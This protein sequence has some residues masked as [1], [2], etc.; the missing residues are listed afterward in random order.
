MFGIE[1]KER[2]KFMEIFVIALK[3]L[4]VENSLILKMINEFSQDD[5]IELFGGNVLTIQYK[6]NLNFGKSMSILQ[7]KNILN[8]SIEKAKEIIKLNKKNKIKTILIS[9]KNYPQNLKNIPNPPAL[10]YFKGRGFYKKHTKSIA[11]VGTRNI[12]EFGYNWVNELVPKLVNE[13]FTIISGLAEGIDSESHKSCISNNGTTIAV[14]AHGLDMIY[15]SQNKDLADSILKNNGLIISEYPI[16]TEP[17]KQYFVKRNRIIS[18][19][20]QGVIVFET[21]EKSGTMHTV[22]YATD[23][24]KLIFTPLPK[25]L[26]ETT[27]A[28][29]KLCEDKISN[30]IVSPENYDKILHMLGYKI[31]NDKIKIKENRLNNTIGILTNMDLNKSILNDNLDFNDKKTMSVTVN[32]ELYEQYKKFLDINNVKNKDI[33][34]ALLLSFLKYYSKK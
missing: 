29:Y 15:P 27:T 11:C 9:D 17:Q 28:L 21:K 33:I 5:F 30:P 3:I 26:N 10:L 16:G 31:K 6:Y 14:V 7:D 24:K 32:S 34:N 1:T 2:S 20:S 19:L 12:S 18:G 25:I 8:D 22:N 4:N 13:N 23:Q